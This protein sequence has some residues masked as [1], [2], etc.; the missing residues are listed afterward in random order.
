MNIFY[1]NIAKLNYI[2]NHPQIMFYNC[3]PL[4]RI[5]T[6]IALDQSSK[7]Q[8]ICAIFLS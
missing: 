6:Q 3:W 5:C 1:P 4:S 7:K 2:K 8:Q